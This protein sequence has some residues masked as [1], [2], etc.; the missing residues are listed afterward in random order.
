MKEYDLKRFVAP[1]TSDYDT[2]L[3]EIKAGRKRSHWIWYIFPQLK[4]LGRSYNSEYYGIEN[5]EEAREYL[6]H[7]L[8]GEHLREITAALL[9]LEG[10]DPVKVMGSIDALKLKSSMTLF[11]AVSEEGSVFH[12]V[13]DKYFDGE[14]DEMTLSILGGNVRT[15]D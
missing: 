11:A 1:N 12:R 13:L 7:P 10:N 2:A 9:E 15:T 5:A 6:M 4:G 3:S 14:R 8:L